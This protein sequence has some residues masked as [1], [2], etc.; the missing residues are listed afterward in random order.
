[1]ALFTTN[2]A[3]SELD[4]R[5]KRFS[6]KDLENVVSQEDKLDDKF[7]NQDRLKVHFSDFK[8]LFGMLRDYTSR[9]YTDVPWFIISAIGAAF[10]Y[11][12]SPIDLIPDFIPFIGY[13]DDATV[14]AFCLNLVHKD[15]MLYK[16]WKEENILKANS[17]GRD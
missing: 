11:V 6:D 10:L 4:K 14:L 5:Q 12:I 16:I 8:I 9:R 1:M 17:A 3:A 13:L 7:R 2:D 15:I